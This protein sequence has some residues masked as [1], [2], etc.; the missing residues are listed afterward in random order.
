LGVGALIFE[1][2]RILLAERGKDPLKGW[3]SLPGGI[4][5]TGEKLADAMRREVRE[6]TGLEVEVVSMFE[7]F[8][9]VIPD[10]AGRAEYHY[11]LIDYL[12]KVVGGTL[13]AAS[14][15]SRAA[16]VSQS[17]LSNY[18]VT[19]GTVAVVERAFAELQR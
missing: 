3:W 6:E 19:E 8:E 17:E 18:R 9:R 10:D 11:V 5:E 15:V 13:E 1:K 12:C 14:D 4:V 2:G 7:I 16:W